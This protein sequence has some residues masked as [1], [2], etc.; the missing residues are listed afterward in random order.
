MNTLMARLKIVVLIGCFFLPAAA[1]G[2]D[3]N[4]PHITGNA[5][6]WNNYLQ[7]SNNSLEP[8]EFNVV[9]FDDGVQ[10][11]E[12]T[13]ELPALG[14]VVVNLK[15]DLDT[16][17]AKGT[18]R[19]TST[20]N[21]LTYRLLY[22]SLPAN[23]LAEFALNDDGYKK[24]AFYF[25]NVDPILVWKAIAVNNLGNTSAEVTLYAVGSNQILGTAPVTIA[26]NSKVVG[27]YTT[28]F[29][30]VPFED[31]ER[32]VAVSENDLTG[33]TISGNA[34]NG[35][36]LFMPAAGA[37]GFEPPPAEEA[38]SEGDAVE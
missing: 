4:I 33:I 23:G 13:F 20:S 30:D 2:N 3:A 14:N 5:G 25:T 17:N 16:D 24:L 10:S 11:G 1:F 19:V 12:K 32:I 34:D 38:A 26:G 7:V 6:V 31:I 15:E 27:E 29:P 9:V 35:I 21:N 37:E 36:L 8:A 28:W 22:Q 18:G